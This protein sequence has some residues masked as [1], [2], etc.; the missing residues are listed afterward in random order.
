MTAGI[1][2]FQWTGDNWAFDAQ[3]DQTLDPF[4]Q[5]A[6]AQALIQAQAAQTLDAF[7]QTATAQALI[8]AQ[9]SQ[10]LGAF[11]QSA[12]GQLLIQA[13]A[14][15]TLGAFTQV[16]TATL[17]IQG[18]AAQVLSAFTQVATAT[19]VA[20][21]V[22]E[23]AA[24]G[25]YHFLERRKRPPK[26]LRMS[27][28][29]APDEVRPPAVKDKVIQVPIGTRAQRRTMPIVKASSP[30]NPWSSEG[31]K[32]RLNIRRSNEWLMFGA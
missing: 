10:T 16:S 21:S 7:T 9:A 5:T 24:T 28:R 3:A 15:Q 12:A 22:Q 18:Q 6:T 8:Q 20:V 11:T 13:V 30:Q 2:F 19:K 26:R 32:R 27:R 23:P 25:G 4:T 31:A 14:S 17:L 29:Q 1:W